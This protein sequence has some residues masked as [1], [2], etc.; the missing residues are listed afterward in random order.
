[1]MAY[2]LAYNLSSSEVISI[3]YDSKTS[4]NFD[5]SSGKTISNIENL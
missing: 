5:K 3:G 4:W 2:Y 1:M